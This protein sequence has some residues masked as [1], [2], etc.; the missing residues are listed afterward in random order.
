MKKISRESVT[1]IIIGITVITAN[2]Y[3]VLNQWVTNPKGSLFTG[4]AHYFADYFLYTSLM[5]QKGWIFTHHLFTNEALPPTWIYWLYTLLGKLGN[6]FVIYNVSIV[7][8]SVVLLTLWWIVMKEIFPKKI[9]NQIIAFLFVATA[10]NVPGLGDFWFSPTPAL[11]RLGGVPHQF[12]QTI[13]LLLVIRMFLSAAS[14]P[15][16]AS[17]ALLI[18]RYLLLFA[19]SF[20]AATASP[21]QMLLIVASACIFLIISLRSNNRSYIAPFA[22]VAVPALMGAYLTNMEFA[23]QP[24]LAA[25]KLWE[26]SQPVS[27]PI[28]QCILAI[29]P[30]SL[31]LPFGIKHYLKNITPLRSLLGIFSALSLAAFFSIVPKLFGT[32]SVRWLSP[33]SVGVLPIIA[34]YGFIELSG[35]TKRVTRT[36][37]PLLHIHLWLLI[38]LVLTVLSLYTQIQARMKPLQSDPTM[39]ALNHVSL[40]VMDALIFLKDSPG[41][42]VVVT[43]PAVPYDVLVPVMTGKRSF[44]GHPIHTLYPQTKEELRR[45]FFSGVMTESEA[46]QFIKNHTISYVL[47]SRQ[48]T[49]ILGRFTFLTPAFQNDTLAVYTTQP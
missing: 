28:W 36:T 42:G 4:I 49:R 47:A 45:K 13:L 2:S 3:H 14:L 21:I 26:D 18:S 23:R 5:A 1:A 37:L 48:A 10:S 16:R 25:A 12:I 35:L 9:F 19:A 24:I 11:N 41:N 38:Y 6:P 40:P 8:F 43:D 34:A 44:T 30:I 17:A 15:S 7:V 20:L 31:F 46:G 32:T 33:A 39:Q 22:T 27:V 29:G